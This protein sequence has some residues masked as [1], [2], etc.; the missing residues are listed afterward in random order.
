MKAAWIVAFGAASLVRDNQIVD[1]FHI[2]YGQELKG[3]V[4]WQD[5]SAPP[6]TSGQSLQ[7]FHR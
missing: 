4:T 5:Y 7:R 3:F 6:H 2:L 1:A